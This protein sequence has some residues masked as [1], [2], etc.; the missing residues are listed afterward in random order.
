MKMR[1]FVFGSFMQPS[2]HLVRLNSFVRRFQ[3]NNVQ[4][5]GVITRTLPLKNR[6]GTYFN[7][8]RTLRL[9]Y[10]TVHKKKTQNDDLPVYFVKDFSS[11]ES[12]EKIRSF[13]PDLMVFIGGREILKPHLLEIPTIGTLGGHFGKLPEMRGMNVTE[14]ALFHS[15]NPAVSIQFIDAG[16][17]TG[18]IVFVR[19]IPIERDDTIKSLREKSNLLCQ[20]LLV[21]A[22]KLVLEG[23]CPR[24]H[25]KPE[26]GK[27]YFTMHHRLIEIA[28]RNLSK[29]Q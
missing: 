10:R 28:Q 22:T 8:R 2:A 11:K 29:M 17:D 9:M 7:P 25:Q 26:E 14:W 21:D 24:Q 3:D 23:K 18:D 6:V 1:I 20:Q 13:K 5:T 16:V 15:K 12:I 19:Q 4:L 27:Q